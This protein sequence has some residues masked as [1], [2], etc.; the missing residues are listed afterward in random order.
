MRWRRAD[1]SVDSFNELLPVAEDTGL[2][3]SLGRKRWRR[4]AGSCKTGPRNCL[5]A[6]STLTVN[7]SQRQFYHPDM[8]AQLKMA[9]AAT[10]VDATRLLFEISESA[11]NEN[12]DAAVAILQRMVDC[13]VRIAVDNFGSNLASLNLLVLAS[14]ST[15]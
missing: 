3:I 12:P 7:V 2:S 5:S 1:G 11:L 14:P 6:I 13:N 15:L 9:L 10:G 4:S 8:V